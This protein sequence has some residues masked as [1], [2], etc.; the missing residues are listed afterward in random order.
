[1]LWEINFDGE[2]CQ[3]FFER[4]IVVKFNNEILSG[5]F[6]FLVSQG[7]RSPKRSFFLINE[8]KKKSMNPLMAHWESY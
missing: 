7:K 6:V 4:T 2:E 8:Y 5:N 1:M 3:S